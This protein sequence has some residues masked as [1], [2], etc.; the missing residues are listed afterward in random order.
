M[1]KDKATFGHRAGVV[2]ICRSEWGVEDNRRVD[3]QN[4]PH[5]HNKVLLSHKE[6]QHS[7][8]YRTLAESWGRI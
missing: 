3:K 2:V 5:M 4:V 1:G 7:A 6:E 8:I